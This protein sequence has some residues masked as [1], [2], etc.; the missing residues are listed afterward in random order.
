MAL[1][2]LTPVEG[3]DPLVLGADRK[4]L[5]ASPELETFREKLQR[6]I[7]PRVLPMVKAAIL[8]GEPSSGQEEAGAFCGSEE[9]PTMAV[10]GP[11]VFDGHP[12]TLSECGRAF[13]DRLPLLQEQAEWLEKTAAFG[14]GDWTDQENVWL[15]ILTG[16]VKSGRRAMLVKEE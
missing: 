12:Y 14:A 1:Y 13:M 3:E 2:W 6:R 4:L 11:V 8:P 16:W 10:P 15:R 5:Q 7:H 9:A